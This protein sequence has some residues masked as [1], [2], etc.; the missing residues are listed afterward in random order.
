MLLT[1]N[2]D[3]T[4]PISQNNAKLCFAYQHCFLT[5]EKMDTCKIDLWKW[6]FVLLENIHCFGVSN[7]IF[8]WSW[9]YIKVF[10]TPLSGFFVCSETGM[11]RSDWSLSS[12]EYFMINMAMIYSKL[13]T[14]FIEKVSGFVIKP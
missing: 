12:D 4:L 8:D 5:S 10:N 14:L 1:S 9:R 6:Y 7:R 13:I 3:D 2:D 11:T